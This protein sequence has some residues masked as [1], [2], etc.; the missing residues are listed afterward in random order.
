MCM[1]VSVKYRTRRFLQYLIARH[2]GA[3]IGK[4]SRYL[5]TSS[6]CCVLYALESFEYLI[7]SADFTDV[8]KSVVVESYLHAESESYIS[9]EELYASYLTNITKTTVFRYT[10]TNHSE[11][12]K[13]EGAV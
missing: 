10:K 2:F 8:P 12:Y 11:V 5:E 4:V 3:E 6:I 7:L 9:W 1:T 13:T